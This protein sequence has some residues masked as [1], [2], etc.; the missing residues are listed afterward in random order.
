MVQEVVLLVGTCRDWQAKLNPAAAAATAAGTASVAIAKS[1]GTA[2]GGAAAQGGKGGKVLQVPAGA[3][4]F[5]SDMAFVGASEACGGQ[6][7]ESMLARWL[8][9][10]PAGEFPRGVDCLSRLVTFSSHSHRYYKVT[11]AS[12]Q[13][14][15]SAYEGVYVCSDAVSETTPRI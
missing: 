14:W 12:S 13:E 6:S 2:G 11:A 7:R 5:G 10:S 1:T 9:L 3:V 15:T 8:G 4:E